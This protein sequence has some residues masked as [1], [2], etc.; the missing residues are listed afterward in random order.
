MAEQPRL[1]RP[2]W[3][4]RLFVRLEGGSDD[5]TGQD[6]SKPYK[7]PVVKDAVDQ[8]VVE[9]K[10]AEV[11]AGMAVGGVRSLSD[12]VG[13]QSQS[14]SLGRHIK[15]T[16]SGNM[17]SSAG[18]DAKGD[19]Y[20]VNF[21]TVPME[22]SIEDK[23]FSTAGELTASFPYQDMPL[24][25]RIIR[26]C[27][28]EAWI[29]TVT[30]EDFAT[31]DK[32]HLKAGAMNDTCVLRF[33]GYV[34]PAEMEH[35][36]SAGDIHLKARSYE[37]V[38]IDGKIAA[39]AKAYR[40][41]AKSGKEP[42]TVY[43]NRILSQYPPTS[44]EH[45]DPLRAYWYA[46]D[47]TK[48]PNVDRK[49][50]L[51][52]L[53]SAASRNDSAGNTSPNV[54]PAPLAEPVGEASDI[55]GQG[56]ISTGGDP[57]MPPKALSEDGMSIWDLI[58]QVC[59]LSGCLPYYSPS[60]PVRE[61]ST[62]GKLVMVDPAN[63]ILISPPQAFL[64]D[65]SRATVIDGGAKDN[66][67]R[68]FTDAEGR[69]FPSDV[70][71]MVWGHNIG[72]LKLSRKLGKVKPSAVEVR[73]YNPD[74]AAHLRVMSARYPAHPKPGE[75]GQGGGGKSANKT[76]EK[77]GGKI[78]VV[79]TFILKGTRSQHALEQAAVSI[80]HQLTRAELTVEV[81]TDDMASFID[82]EASRKQNKLVPSH[83]GN[84]DLLRL[85]AGTPVHITVARKPDDNS[86][87]IVISSLSDF[88]DRGAN[89][90]EL[91]TKQNDR[92][93]MWRKDG[94]LDQAGIEL[95]AQRIQAAYRAAKLPDV[96][97]CRSVKLRFSAD[98]GFNMHMELASYMDANNPNRFS[99]DDRAKTDERKR[100]KHGA[101]R[102]AQNTKAS[103][104]AV[105]EDTRR[106]AAL[107]HQSNQGGRGG[108]P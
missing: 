38:L 56:D 51:R 24:D 86:D 25:P 48:E 29:G 4:L 8:A 52:T 35:D 11:S 31:P 63:S 78:A 12:L 9:A 17:R 28:V 72:K 5:G 92:W 71:F 40:I 77:G 107:I 30:G 37:A 98:D 101:A 54:D 57:A 76:T 6:G 100:K 44:G 39:N 58:K 47:P 104:D 75:V 45:G 94:S 80:Y 74:A 96:F 89:I 42:L 79:R 88:Y 106:R 20:S 7:T 66:F 10:I 93:G 102:D 87:A 53:Q 61:G 73:A 99:K 34:D 68:D 32:W 91:L 81:E 13:L 95:T 108:A 19:K 64:D 97:Y 65:I 59:E 50:L 67:R 84:P 85:C 41:T 36:E 55:H 22:L 70:R 60:L 14:A 27:R 1:Y 83:N 26:E 2:A 21:V 69:V 105:V 23:G 90:V 15:A 49:T 43:I 62:D 3:F 82:P 46:A 16:A 33:N 103:S 18:D